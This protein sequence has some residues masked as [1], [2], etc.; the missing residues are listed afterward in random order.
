MKT[1]AKVCSIPDKHWQPLVTILATRLRA[2]PMHRRLPA[3]RGLLSFNCKKKCEG[4]LAGPH[5]FAICCGLS[6]GFHSRLLAFI[7]VYLLSFS[8]LNDAGLTLSCRILALASSYFAQ[9]NLGTVFVS[10]GFY[11]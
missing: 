7:L 5:S 10:E 6:Q 9:D 8:L 11:E 3:D 1:T 2:T 4:T